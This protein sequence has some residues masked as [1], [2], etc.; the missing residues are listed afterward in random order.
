MTDKARDR[1]IEELTG[2]LETLGADPA[3]WPAARRAPMMS[4]IASNA[5]AR[6]RHRE[7]LAMD[8]LIS[9]GDPL[10]GHDRVGPER[11]AR[12]SSRLMD[13]IQ[14]TPQIT[15]RPLVVETP[16][17]PAGVVV[18]LSRR[19][20]PRQSIGTAVA[21]QATAVR[22]PW[23]AGALIAASLVAGLLIGALDVMPVSID[24]L[25]T[26]TGSETAQTLAAL[27]TDGLTLVIEEEPL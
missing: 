19:M 10:G 3:R 11:M 9:R 4:L 20:D 13:E 21:A 5:A 2:L 27:Q 14:R 23:R 8:S 1:D 12:L 6:A 17:K 26:T 15:A 24:R 7:A 18:P 16:A 25:L 22:G